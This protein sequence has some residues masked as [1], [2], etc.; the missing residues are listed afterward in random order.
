MLCRVCNLQLNIRGMK[1]YRSFNPALCSNGATRPQGSSTSTD[2][3]V[4]VD[5]NI[6]LNQ[7]FWSEVDSSPGDRYAR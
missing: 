3:R 7:C 1:M 4:V 5:A 2:T 6:H